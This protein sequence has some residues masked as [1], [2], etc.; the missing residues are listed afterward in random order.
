MTSAEATITYVP[1]R[2]M[3]EGISFRSTLLPGVNQM[4][5]LYLHSRVWKK[6]RIDS[7]DAVEVTLER[8]DEPR[9]ITVPAELAAALA[10]HR[11]ALNALQ[12]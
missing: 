2:G 1:V 7:G 6:L 10:E 12:A 11:G 4:Y 8:D 5:R 9:E 3:A